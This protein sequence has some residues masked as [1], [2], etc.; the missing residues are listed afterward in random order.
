MLSPHTAPLIMMAVY[1]GEDWVEN[2]KLLVH[3]TTNE[4]REA[5]GLGR[6]QSGKGPCAFKR[7]NLCIYLC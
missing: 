6:A 1:D 3:G 2:G 7:S 4:R 5:E